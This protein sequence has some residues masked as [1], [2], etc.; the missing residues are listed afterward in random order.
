M[1]PVVTR[2][3][4]AP[5]VLLLSAAL[6]S[7]ASAGAIGVAD[8]P[9]PHVGGWAVDLTGV[10]EAG[11]L[12]ALDRLGDE[13]KAQTGAEL[14][15][16]VIGSTDGVPHRQF[17][18]ELANRW[19]IGDREKDNGV[20]VFAALDD[21]AAEITL[22]EGIDDAG[23]VAI[24]LDIMHGV[25][26]P[27]FRD[28]DARGAV[29]AGALACARRILGATPTMAEPPLPL[30]TPGLEM[31]LDSQYATAPASAEPTM[32][33]YAA[34]YLAR[35]SVSP[36]NTFRLLWG[37]V[38]G[39]IALL[40]GGRYWYRRRPRRCPSCQT[41]MVRL[42]EDADD[43]R[44]SSGEQAEERVGSVNYDVWV[45]PGCEEIEKVRYGAFFTRYATCPQC[46]AR[47]VSSWSRVEEE[48]PTWS[49]G[50]RRIDESC[51]H[52]HYRDSHVRRI[53]RREETTSS[54]LSSDSSFSRSS[55]SSSSSSSVSTSSSSSSS[56]SEHGGGSSAGSGASGRW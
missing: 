52:C 11:D 22:G 23:N 4:P 53:P 36:T 14:A 2:F 41:E 20:L 3:F 35:T 8:V 50:R 19:G 12:Q 26:V 34:S 48:A 44:L 49:E 51:E 33:S 7:A 37:A 54:R 17:A 43:A 9:A 16:A 46:G 55:S 24:A 29:L 47:T 38:G 30:A 21:R 1:H 28:G 10:L 32:A 42:D 25:M 31:A 40:A 39:L 18:T 13:V 15:V 27:R 6:L 45:C 5:S 56:S